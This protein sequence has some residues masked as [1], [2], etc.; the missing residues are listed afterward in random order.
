MDDYINSE[1]V[2]P[3]GVEKQDKALAHLLTIITAALRRACCS[4]ALFQS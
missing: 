4:F 2:K 3:A 1:Q